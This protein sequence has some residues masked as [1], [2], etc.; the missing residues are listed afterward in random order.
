[1]AQ[2]RKDI[3][4]YL[5]NGR[6]IFEVMMLADQYGNLVGPANPS[7]MAVDAFG[8]ART[9]SPLTLFDSNHRYSDNGLWAT[10]TATGGAAVFNANQ[11][12]VDLNVTGASGSEVIRETFK[13]FAYQPGKSLQILNT[14]CFNEAKTN[15]RQR[16]GYFGASNGF[17]V[18]LNDSTLSFVKRSSVSGSLVETKISQLGSVY[19]AE[20]TGWNLDKLDGTGPSGY[21]IDKTKSHIFW[22]DLEW[23]GVG[24][25]RMGVVINSQFIHCHSFH[26]AN[27]IT[28]TYITTASLPVRYEI[29]NTG[30]TSGPSTLKQ[31]CSTV[32]SEGGYELR[33]SQ[34][35]VNVPITAPRT[36]A[37][38]GTHYPVI[39]LELKSSKLDAIVIPT[40]ISLMGQGNGIFYHWQLTQ[41]AT[42]TGGTWIDSGTNS[43]VNYNLTGTGVSG[44][45]VV[46]SGF[47]SSTNQ[48]HQTVTV[49][50]ENLFR[51]QLERNGLTNTPLSLSLSVAA[52][53]A[54]QTIFGSMD[55]EEVTR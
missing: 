50:K 3:H 29:R 14:F 15:L 47:T 2:F 6:T 53:T 13:V 36:L 19:G 24:T 31:I 42:V 26:H 9:S 7:G 8:R 23:L 16:V 37:V 49:N 41:S 35:A 51:F 12:L 48:S 28:A 40:N 22:M 25:V 5:N 18:E 45:R 32:I 46:A 17:Y 54:N 38:A 4:Q 20:D 55:W 27:L 21:T 52:A 44:G 11:G 10:S 39:A 33:G 43:A 30:T 1:M 34:L